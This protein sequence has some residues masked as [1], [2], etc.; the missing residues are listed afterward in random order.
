MDRTLDLYLLETQMP[1][2]PSQ[3]LLEQLQLEQAERAQQLAKE[4]S[5]RQKS[6]THEFLKQF[7]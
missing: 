3:A 1:K 4:I 6:W 7:A 2:S 5:E